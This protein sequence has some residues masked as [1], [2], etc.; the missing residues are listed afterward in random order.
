MYG[1]FGKG[2]AVRKRKFLNKTIKDHGE[3]FKAVKNNKV[4][5]FDSMNSMVELIN[6]QIEIEHNKAIV[7][8]KLDIVG[9][10]ETKFSGGKADV[11]IANLGF[12]Y[13]HRV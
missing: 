7:D 13:S 5:L 11:I 6:S 4:S 12:Q 1:S 9:L 10:L 2:T 8:Y 3:H